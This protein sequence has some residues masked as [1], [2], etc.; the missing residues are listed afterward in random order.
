MG[1]SSSSGPCTSTANQGQNGNVPQCLDKFSCVNAEGSGNV[2]VQY[3]ITS[4]GGVQSECFTG[5]TSVACAT[6]IDLMKDPTTKNIWAYGAGSRGSGSTICY[7]ALCDTIDDSKCFAAGGKPS[8]VCA[9]SIGGNFSETVFGGGTGVS[10]LNVTCQWDITNFSTLEAI[11]AYET[12]FFGTA[13]SC[14]EPPCPL[15]GVD[16]V[17][18]EIIMPFFCSLQ[19]EDTPAAPDTCP[20]ANLAGP[21]VKN[22]AGVS[23]CSRMVARNEAG[24]KC[25]EWIQRISGNKEATNTANAEVFI[26][27]CDTLRTDSL[28][29][30]GLMGGEANECLCINAGRGGPEGL[31][32]Q[33]SEAAREAG[34]SISPSVLGQLGCWYAPCNDGLTQL[35]PLETPLTQGKYY[36][37][38]CP[39]VCVIINNIKGKIIGSTIKETINCKGGGTT[40]V[41]PG[42]TPVTP[43][44]PPGTSDPGNGA[45]TEL[46]FW[47]RYKWWIIGGIAII[48]IIIFLVIGFGFFEAER[49]HKEKEQQVPMLF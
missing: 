2:C 27:Y 29:E 22:S 42:E 12:E 36:P 19:E 6:S 21:W 3:T 17:L 24:N 23:K 32:G 35:V 41:P 5:N 1:C 18:D 44:Q 8:N 15:G 48:V 43:L 47:D 45:P 7:A 37:T 34:T 38:N 10:S 28:S 13:G 31:L 9:G 16:N 20:K 30:P 26:G 40:P 11:V 25:T 4:T 39:P 49:K 14:K 46:S 33:I